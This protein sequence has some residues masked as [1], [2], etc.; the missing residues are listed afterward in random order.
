MKIAIIGTAYPFR[1]GLS[2]FNERL[3]KEL[4]DQGHEVTIYTFTLQYPKF[5]FPGK[6]QYSSDPR[7]EHLKIEE[8]ISSVNPFNWFKVGNRIKKD[9]PD[10][11]IVKFWLPFMGPCFGTILRKIRKNKHTKIVTII[12]NIIPH[13]KRF[14]DKMFTKYFVKRIDAFMVMSKSVL[15]DVDQFD[16]AK[17][18]T[19]SPHPIYDNFGVQ[20]TRNEALEKLGFDVNLKYM[21]FFGLI[22]DYKG[23]DLLIQ[24][25]A[26]QRIKDQNLK[27]IIAGEFYSDKEK[28]LNLIKENELGDAVIQVDKFIPDSEVADYFNACDLVVQ[29]YKAATQSGVTQI[30]Y[31]F[32]KPMIVTK[33]GGLEE[34]CPDGKVG[35]VVAPEPNAISD[36][37]IRYFNDT[38][39]DQM[40]QFIE[41]EK[42]KYS[43]EI[44]TQNMFTLIDEIK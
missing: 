28:Y 2:A 25:M 30:A 5:L 18:R 39:P 34:M 40:V 4:Q 21:L 33:V 19:F 17:P 11:V 9:K 22:R 35:Y 13:E 8:C 15:R 1:G 6:S 42:K 7:P 43:W 41:E 24:S 3:A 36:G 26:D 44:F 37:I 16:T 12:D 32:N 31:H 38:D 10:L 27:L 29:P 23:L 14:G 20:T